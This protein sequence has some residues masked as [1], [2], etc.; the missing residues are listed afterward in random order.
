[1]RTTLNIDDEVLAK[2]RQYAK[3]RKMPLVKAVNFLLE[4]GLRLVGM[5]VENGIADFET[6]KEFECLEPKQTMRVSDKHLMRA[7]L[8]SG[9]SRTCGSEE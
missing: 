9:N 8:S 1:M 2:V 7:C 3:D 4:R 5:P 6:P